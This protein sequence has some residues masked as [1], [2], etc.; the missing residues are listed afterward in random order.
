MFKIII[1]SV[2]KNIQNLNTPIPKEKNE[3]KIKPNKPSLFLLY[4]LVLFNSSFP[5]LLYVQEVVTHFIYSN[6]LYK[7][8]HYF[9]DTQQ[10][11]LLS[12]DLFQY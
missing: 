1:H 2:Q 4:D 3:E 11:Q 7:M 8:R 12:I 9:L 6:L 10:F 5:V